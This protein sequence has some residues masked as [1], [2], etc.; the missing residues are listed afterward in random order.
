MRTGFPCHSTTCGVANAL[1]K[2]PSAFGLPSGSRSL[3]SIDRWRLPDRL[4][5]LL[6]ERDDVLD[7]A[8]VEVHE[9]QV[10]EDDRRRPGAAKVIA[11]E[12]AARP[13]HLAGR[14]VERRGARRTE[15]HVDASRLDRPAS[16]R[17][18]C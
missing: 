2:S 13:Q 12:I 11:L 17:R 16:A 5:G 10:P 4:S 1:R 7:V 8:A 3:K 14:G 18:S 15:R 6:V 9:Q